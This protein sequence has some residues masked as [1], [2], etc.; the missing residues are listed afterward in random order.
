MGRARQC[1]VFGSLAVLAHG[2]HPT[3][4]HRQVRTRHGH[5]PGPRCEFRLR[6]AAASIN[7]LRRRTLRFVTRS[8]ALKIRHR[9]SSW[10]SCCAA[11]P[12]GSAC[13]A[14]AHLHRRSLGSRCCGRQ[15][16]SVQGSAARGLRFEVERDSFSRPR[17]EQIAV[18][19][20]GA[21]GGLSLSSWPC[22]WAVV[23]TGWSG[24]RSGFAT[25]GPHPGPVR[26]PVDRSARR[27][28][29]DRQGPRAHPDSDDRRCCRHRH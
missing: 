10:F 13:R 26:R 23:T 2:E 9:S 16:R 21:L 7:S 15:R 8:C 17:R 19:A 14:L 25:G 29:P 5:Q 12:S 22:R 20:L 28:P 27:Q 1:C 6:A 24:G 4:R 3:V 18:K 11:F